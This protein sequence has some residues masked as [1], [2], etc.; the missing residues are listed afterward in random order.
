M[1]NAFSVPRTV[2]N[3]DVGRSV[4]LFTR[5]DSAEAVA[6]AG[7]GRAATGDTL[8]ETLEVRVIDT[9]EWDDGFD[10]LAA[11]TALLVLSK[12]SR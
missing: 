10:G 4:L 3:G 7:A 6:A 11:E 1:D 9:V 2:P 5:S 8:K 12:N